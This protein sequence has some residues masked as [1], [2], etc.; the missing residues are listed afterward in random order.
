[1]L[2]IERPED[3]IPE[4]AFALF[5]LGFRPFFALAGLSAVVLMLLW[6]PFFH[7]HLALNGYYGVSGW[8]AHEMLFGYSLAVI[9]GFLL[10]AARNWTAMATPT[11]APLIGLTLVWIAGRLL[12]TLDL[13]QPGW[14]I[15]LVDLSFAPLVM[16]GLAKPLLRAKVGRNI[17]FLLILTLFTIANLLMHLQ[18]LGVANTAALG[19]QMG[20]NLVLLMIVILGGR[21]IPMFTRNPLPGMV[22]RQ[23]R[24][25]EIAAVAGVILAM[26]ADLLPLPASMAALV[27]I[28]V[29][30]IHL[31]RLS[32]WYDR[33]IWRHPIIWV[34]HVAY[35]W[36]ALGFCLKGLAALG[37]VSGS[38][39]THSLAVGGIGMVT[40]GMMGRVSLGHTGRM[41][42]LPSL[43]VWG[44]YLL[45]AAAV[46]RVAAGI[47][48]F[49]SAYLT[50]ISLSALLWVMAFS[51][52]CYNYWPY[53]F[54][55]R[56]DGRPG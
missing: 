13:G 4:R 39:A 14:L 3:R 35:G 32:G 23:W 27:F 42:E 44:I 20:L 51:C 37:L 55:P 31:L 10:T 11:G 52:F 36:I 19:I 49:N 17:A 26:V 38:A 5:F 25:V 15:T 54:K 18:A 2:N 7:G 50:L 40:L 45:T 21:V 28:A 33:R 6:I 12:S 30:A 22:L 53:L 24:L 56:V 47:A 41:L 43:T 48:A 9:A 34:L 8:H 46:V 1:M 16:L 29:G